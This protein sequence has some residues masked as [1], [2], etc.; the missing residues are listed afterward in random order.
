MIQLSKYRLR[1]LDD[2]NWTVEKGKIP[3]DGKNAGQWIA[4]NKS[5]FPNP[6]AAA[7]WLYD[8]LL[9][10][11]GIEFND[12]KD[13]GELVER[14]RNEILEAVEQLQKESNK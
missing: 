2:L 14:Y 7:L 12:L 4:Y 13:L 10:E 3:Q 1:R 9:L 11:E 6:G 5:F 8:R